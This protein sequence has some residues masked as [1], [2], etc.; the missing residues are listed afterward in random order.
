MF[1]EN[2]KIKQYL[3]TNPALQKLLD[4]KFSPKKDNHTDDS[5]LNKESHTA[6]TKRKAAHITTST[7]IIGIKN[8]WP[9]LLLN[10]NGFNFPIKRYRITEWM[11]NRICLSGA[12]EKHALK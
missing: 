8:H 2:I 3:S 7:Q 5:I 11:G 9:L 6:N 4:H 1:H 10:I 12:K